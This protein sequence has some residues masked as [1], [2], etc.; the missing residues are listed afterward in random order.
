MKS[1]F[2]LSKNLN[3]DKLTIWGSFY[4]CTTNISFL[5]LI[6]DSLDYAIKC[7]YTS[8]VFYTIC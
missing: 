6:N 8:H 2:I 5:F 7:S 4:N 1:S 3:A